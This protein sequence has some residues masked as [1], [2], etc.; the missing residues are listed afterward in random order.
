MQ[1]EIRQL[2]KEQSDQGFRSS[3]IRDSGTVWSGSTMFA[4]LYI[5]NLTRVVISYEIYETSFINFIWNDHSCKI[6]FIIMTI[7]NEI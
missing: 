7:L 5:K 1:T 6:L 3:L 2:L 4:I